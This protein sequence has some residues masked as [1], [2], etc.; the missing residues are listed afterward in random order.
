[1]E[2]AVVMTGV[3]GQG[4][5]LIAKLL[6]QAAM[7]EGR[8]V[9]MFGVF[10]G[11]IRGGESESTVVVADGE[12]LT[13]P[14]VP[15]AWGVVA[16]HPSGLA[17]LAAKIEQGGVLVVNTSLV[18]KPPVWEG[19]RRIDVPATALAAELG[20]PLGAGMVVLGALAAA[21]GLV[22]VASLEAALADVLPP[23]RRAQIEGNR[24]CLARGAAAVVG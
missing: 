3:G 13:P 21:T 6:G 24:A 23:H 5:Q 22:A 14:I 17:P 10:K 15:R 20:Q 11:T 18:T 9:L 19:V 4:I 2:R 16:M 1:V 7:R 8:E 12:I